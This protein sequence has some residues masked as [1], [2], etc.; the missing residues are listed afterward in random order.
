MTTQLFKFQI[1]SNFSKFLILLFIIRFPF[2]WNL[3]ITQLRIDLF[4]QNQLQRFELSTESRSP[5]RLLT[6]RGRIH[7][8]F[9]CLNQ[10]F[11]K[12]VKKLLFNRKSFELL[13]EYIT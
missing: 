9:S 11:D 5:H 13:P 7:L 6:R 1:T 12:V 3:N 10:Y 4:N 8:A 2:V